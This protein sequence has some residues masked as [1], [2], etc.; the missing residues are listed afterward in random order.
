MTDF[1]EYLQKRL[2][3]PE[4]K[5]HYNEYGRQLEIA[6]QI[7]RLR[8]QKRM[9][10]AELAKRIGTKQSNIARL[11]TGQ[12]NFTTETLQKIALVFDRDL[13]IEFV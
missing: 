11:E 8:K 1:Q 4:F 9:S 3:N 10:Q 2:K 6:Y 13:K 5:K 12:Q 7:L